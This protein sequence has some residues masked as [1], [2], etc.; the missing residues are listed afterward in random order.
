V[1]HELG[2]TLVPHGRIIFAVVNPTPILTRFRPRD[3]EQRGS[4]VLEVD[5]T[6]HRHPA[7]LVETLAVVEAGH[8]AHHERRQRLYSPAELEA[9]ME[10]AGFAVQAMFGDYGRAGFAE[11]RSAKVVLLA[12]AAA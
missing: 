1:L 11:A 12:E 2:R 3:V 8:V 9:M 4:V 7:Q 6:L 5:R 10:G